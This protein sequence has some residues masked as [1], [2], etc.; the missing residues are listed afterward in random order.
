LGALLTARSGNDASIRGRPEEG[1]FVGGGRGGRAER[2]RKEK[3]WPE[4]ERKGDQNKDGEWRF[5]GRG[6]GDPSRKKG[7]E[8]VFG[9]FEGMWKGVE[10]LTSDFNA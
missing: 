1:W 2:D 8:A 4:P 3:T 6:I 5:P 7:D 9:N 10:G